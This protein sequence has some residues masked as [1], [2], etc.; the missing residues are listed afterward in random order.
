[1]PYD[2]KADYP[3]QVRQS[4][5][6][7]IEHLGHID[8]FLLHGPRTRGS[9]SSIDRA[10]WRALEDLQ[11]EG[12]TRFIG[13]SNAT[14]EQVAELCSFASI[15]P[16]FVQNRCFA[17]MGW[18]R[19]VREVCKQVVVFAY[20]SMALN[21]A[22]RLMREH[23]SAPV[24]EERDTG[25]LARA[26]GRNDLPHSV[27]PQHS[28][29]ISRPPTSLADGEIAAIEGFQDR[30]GLFFALRGSSAQVYVLEIDRPCP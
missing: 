2:A 11:R 21:E 29:T 1:L 14:A 6:S 9:L 20:R 28:A 27:N 3:T 30:D 7:S 8:S 24:G 25:R 10:V 26:G 5:D 17:R 12:R 16:A 4:F 15:K 19:D 22:A 13:I 18:D 23:P